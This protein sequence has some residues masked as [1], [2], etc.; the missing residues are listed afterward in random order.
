MGKSKKQTSKLK[1]IAKLATHGKVKF[2]LRTRKR[3]ILENQLKNLG[4]QL[5]KKGVID[6]TFLNFVRD[7]KPKE[8]QIEFWKKIL[9]RKDLTPSDLYEISKMIDDEPLKMEAQRKYVAIAPDHDLDDT[10]KYEDDIFQ[11][12]AWQERCERIKKGYIKK[13]R[14]REILIELFK[15]T[16]NY[17]IKIWDVLE[18]L[19]PTDKELQSLLILP[20]MDTMP[21]L[22]GKIERLIR[23]KKKKSDNTKLISKIKNIQGKLTKLKEGQ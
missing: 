13:R 9:N 8:K 2:F 17:R 22:S 3:R 18:W 5:I 21:E 11:E 23:K 14:A 4:Q 6:Q 20:F 19:E 10:I 15:D 7:I 1:T 12:M 16:P